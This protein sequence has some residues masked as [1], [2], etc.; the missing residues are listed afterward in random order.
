[1]IRVAPGPAEAAERRRSNAQIANATSAVAAAPTIQRRDASPSSRRSEPSEERGAPPS[2]AR[3]SECPARTGGAADSGNACRARTFRRR[4]D[5]LPFE[6]SF[7]RAARPGLSATR[8]FA[9]FLVASPPAGFASAARTCGAAALESPPASTKVAVPRAVRPALT[10]AASATIG[11]DVAG[12]RGAP[13]ASWVSD[14]GGAA[15][16]ADAAGG[17]GSFV[18]GEPTGAASARGRNRSGSR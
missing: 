12:C 4:S 18:A 15:A 10:D 5:A 17:G 13:S 16:G 2:T 9:P 11:C 6:T 3:G 1:M 14:A 7:D 8:P